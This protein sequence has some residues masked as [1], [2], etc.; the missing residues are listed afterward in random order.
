MNFEFYKY[1]KEVKRFAKNNFKLSEEELEDFVEDILLKATLK[2]HLFNPDKS[3]IVTWINNISRNH[4]I[5]K[6][7]RK[8]HPEYV[9]ETPETLQES[10]N[11]GIDIKNFKESLMGTP[12]YM[13]F[14]LKSEDKTVKD[15]C[16]ELQISILEYNELNKQLKNKWYEF[17]N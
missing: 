10:S 6:Y 3:A 7:I 13:F 12:L 9:D 11:D 15:I 17:N 5:D 8:K 16:N 4:Y 2:Q 1:K 14:L